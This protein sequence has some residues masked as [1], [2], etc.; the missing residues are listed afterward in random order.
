MTHAMTTISFY[1]AL[2]ALLF[3]ISFGIELVIGNRKI[4]LLRDVLPLTTASW[5][6]VSVIIA[7]RNEERKITEALQSVLGQD[8]PNLEVIVVND[9]STDC[10][11]ELL[12]QVAQ[13]AERLR[14]IHITGLPAGW[15]GKNHALQAGAAISAGDFLLFTDADIV[16]KSDAIR[17]AISYASRQKLD[18]LTVM[19]Q[20]D[21]SGVLLGMALG[22]FAVFFSFFA[23]PW[24]AGNPRSS[25]FIGV[26]AFNL[27]R[28]D[29]YRA[30]GGHQ[31][32]AMRPDDDLKLGKLIKL[33]GGRQELLFGHEMISV[34]WYASLRELIDGLMK[35]MFSGVEYRVSAILAATGILLFF[36]IW[37]Y[38]A[39][40]L[41]S[42]ATFWL[43]LC[44]IVS[45]TLIYLETARAHRLTLW[46]VIGFPLS[47]LIF[48]Y[49]LWRS[50]ILTLWHDG[51]WWRDTHYSLADLRANRL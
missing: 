21:M 39:V 36:V 50:M 9:R 6:R 17:K 46:Q 23:R 51:I 44:V 5:P 2:A 41:S 20:E 25:F 24:R 27:V 26:G 34:E 12:E 33:R 28:A 14:V 7:A 1:L 38:L 32:I 31:A 22:A 11:G 43:Y 42:G 35:N 47:T 49:I 29:V 16:M 10:T 3:W 13:T 19:P 37:P 40:W 18:H 8:Y 45:L 4:R 48:I 30:I 15:L